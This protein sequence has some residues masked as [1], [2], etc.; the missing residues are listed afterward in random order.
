MMEYIGS[1]THQAT[2]KV[3]ADFGST[4]DTAVPDQSC[5]AAGPP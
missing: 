4:H 2:F 5:L 3:K 1:S